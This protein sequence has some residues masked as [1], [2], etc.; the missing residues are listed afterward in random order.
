MP[1]LL[2]LPN[3]PQTIP[4]QVSLS[5]P[6]KPTNHKKPL[7]QASFV[8]TPHL[9]PLNSQ[10]SPNSSAIVDLLQNSR[11]YRPQVSYPQNINYAS[12]SYDL[13]S[14]GGSRNIFPLDL[15]G[16][17]RSAIS[18]PSLCNPGGSRE[19]PQI[20]S[21]N[22]SVSSGDSNNASKCKEYRERS[23]AK[24]EREMREFQEQ[25]C[26]NIKLRAEHDQKVDT[27][28]KLKT[29][30]LQCLK[31]KRFKCVDHTETT[32]AST[33]TIVPE[34]KKSA[35]ALMVTIKSEEAELFTG[36]K[37]EVTADITWE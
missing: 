26:R 24:K 27:I 37:T 32:P 7:P 22:C 23:R 11:H 6:S 14:L 29:F 18:Y 16:S 36:I 15:P 35:P 28:K 9:S 2:R 31:N 30:Y 10:C 21:D 12:V 13:T 19:D 3:T 20:L 5:A 1:P 25:L 33:T 4:L 8:N 34:N 17:S